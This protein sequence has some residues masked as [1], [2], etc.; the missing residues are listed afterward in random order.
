M[1]ATKLS[2]R[3]AILIAVVIVAVS[4]VYI[5]WCIERQ[6]QFGEAKALAEARTLN[7]EMLAAWDYI[8][9]IQNQINYDAT[10]RYDFKNVYCAIAGKAIAQRFMRTSDYEI[11][12]VKSSPRSV[13]DAPDEFELSALQSFAQTGSNEFYG[14]SSYKNQPVFR[15]ASALTYSHNCMLCHGEPAG[16][17]DPTGFLKE[18]MAIGD[19]AG[20]ASIII[21][22]DVY[23]AELRANALTDIAF[24]L[25]LLIAVIGITQLG[26]TLWVQRP[27]RRLGAT[28]RSIGAGAWDTPC[29]EPRAAAEIADLAQSF[30]SMAKELGASYEQLENR[31]TQRTEELSTANRNLS[32]QRTQIEEAFDALQDANERLEEEIAYKSN[33]LS[34]MSHELKTPIV[35]IKAALDIWSRSKTEVSDADR[36]LTEEVGLQCATLLDA[37]ENTLGTSR[38]EAGRFVPNVQDVDPV[39][40]LSEAAASIET[41]ARRRSL[42]VTCE[43]AADVPIIS[44]DWNALERIVG[45][46]VSNAV[47]F[48]PPG[49]TITLSAL[50]SPAI[51]SVT[52]S[53]ADTGIGIAPN[54]TRR[55]FERF[56]QVDSS[57]SREYH[58]SGLG[59]SLAQ[60]LAEHIG[61]VISL[62]STLGQGSTFSLTLPTRWPINPLRT[63]ANHAHIDCR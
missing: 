6:K 19:L 28:A 30:S 17:K 60:D 49:G 58:G 21:P 32:L 18:G 9:D 43:I 39:D 8:N 5:P 4:A 62:E 46:L 41:I 50:Y 57:L 29:S 63:E 54:D 24:F 55:V 47:K 7:Q 15:Y 52:I 14:T 61:G 56:V 37:I 23:E 22:M 27:L 16:E 26:V 53:V 11:R 44:S 34:I 13:T 38:I 31:V 1:G 10:G 3:F 45:N 20:A 2:T 42:T 59:L 25:L 48:T 40:L 12:Y 33:F 51:D 35:S 36:L